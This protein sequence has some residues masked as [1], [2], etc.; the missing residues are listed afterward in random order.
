MS[1]VAELI[2]LLRRCGDSQYGGEAVTQLEHG[3]QAAALAEAGHAPAELIAAALLHDIGHLLHDLP[4]DAPE[5]GTDDHHE[6]SAGR[7]LARLFPPAVCEPVRLHVAAKRY[8][9][10]TDPA[11]QAALSRPSQVSL[12]LQ[13]G[14]MTAGEVDEFR[15][16]PFYDDAVRLR[17]WDD[18]AK[19]PGLTTPPLEH[20]EPYVTASAIQRPSA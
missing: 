20:F 10:A 16:H 12:A 17:K 5:L 1:N 3:L 14:A 8:L 15:R 6:T 9:C 13:G 4:D 19:V 2:D 7:Y 11:Y 18:E